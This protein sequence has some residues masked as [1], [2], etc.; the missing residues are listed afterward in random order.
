MARTSRRGSASTALPKA[1]SA[2]AGA[3][4][5]L[6]SPPASSRYSS[7]TARREGPNSLRSECELSCVITA[8]NERPSVLRRT[9]NGLVRTT[10]AYRREII[11]VDDGSEVPIEAA[12]PHA[13][14]LRNARPLGV[15]RARRRGA[16][17][18]RGRAIVW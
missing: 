15:S 18:A 10:A 3:V 14:L 12:F 11:I 16:A 1:R 2:F 5:R 4:L 13:R 7:P 8:R 17:R 6:R 9:Y